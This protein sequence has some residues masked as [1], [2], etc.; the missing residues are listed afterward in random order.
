MS[1]IANYD[2]IHYDY[3]TY[4]S[5]RDYENN[6]EHN[7]LKKILKD[8]SGKWFLDIGGSFGRLA[9]VYYDKYTHPVI[10]DYSLNT[11]VSN[12]KYLEEKY[13][14]IILIAAN[15]YSLPFK[16]DVFDGGL[17][18]RVLHHIDDVD[19]YIL[20]LK[21]VLNSNSI[22][23]QE[24]A[25]KIH[26]I[27][28][29]RGLIHFN[30]SIFSLEPYQQPNKMNNE[31]A[32]SGKYVPFFN[33]HP[34]WVQDKLEDN[35]FEIISKDGC[36]YLRSQTLKK[37][38]GTNIISNIEYLLQKLIPKSNIPPS[39]FLTTKVK[40]KEKDI[41]YEDINSILICPKCKGKLDI[42]NNKAICSKCKSEYNKIEGIW[43]F[44][45]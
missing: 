44:R 26:L 16:D 43:D 17:M 37:I 4:W 11:L 24:F 13:P 32:R 9:D 1:K 12:K 19:K 28:R 29:I 38:L 27:A 10:I 23:I 2:T 21:R 3:S 18:V 36:S 45:I 41:E 22:Y 40:E 6:A 34:K 25:N 5:N 7:L 35:S 20:E 39:I 14:N 42:K 31:G 30:T 8:E 15:A 33:Y